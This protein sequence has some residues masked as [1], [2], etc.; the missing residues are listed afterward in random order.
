MQKF[1][2]VVAVF[3]FA[4][5]AFSDDVAA[6]QAAYVTKEQ[7]ERAVALLKDKGEIKHHCAPCDDKSIAQA[8]ETK[9]NELKN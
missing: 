1:L 8:D 5:T 2:S 3:I 7:A 9:A 4:L 6:D